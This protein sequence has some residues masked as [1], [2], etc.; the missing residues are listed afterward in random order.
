ME[1]NE[2]DV[3]TFRGGLKGFE[4]QEKYILLNNNDTE[5]PVPFMWLQ[6]VDDPKLTFVVSIPFFLDSTYEFDI[7]DETCEALGVKKPDEV[8]IYSICR[9]R[10][11]V[12]EMT[13]NLASP[14]VINANTHIG[15]QVMLYD[16]NY[17]VDEK[18]KK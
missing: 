1:I 7:P 11:T 15:M 5:D 16:T 4:D 14:L 18:V 6:S 8:G 10:D 2:T 3:I 13:V 17:T 12:E 9:I